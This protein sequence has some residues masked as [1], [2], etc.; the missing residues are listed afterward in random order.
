[1]ELITEGVKHLKWEL[2]L[3]FFANIEIEIPHPFFF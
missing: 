2:L 1:M 3:V